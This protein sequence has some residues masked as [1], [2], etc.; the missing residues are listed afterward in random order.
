MIYC[1]E[2]LKYYVNY[3]FLPW[4]PK[5]SKDKRKRKRKKSL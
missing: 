1:F 2:E 5:G 4:R 3:I